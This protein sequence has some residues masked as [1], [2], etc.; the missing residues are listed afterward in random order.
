M[1]QRVSLVALTMLLASTSPAA[2]DKWIVGAEMGAALTLERDDRVDA[3]GVFA[4]AVGRGFSIGRSWELSLQLNVPMPPGISAQ[5]PLTVRWWPSSTG[6]TVHGAVRPILFAVGVCANDTDRCPM[7]D[8]LE[9]RDRG[10]F[11]L[12]VL[13]G[14]GLGYARGRLYGEVSYLAGWAKGLERDD[15]GERPRTGF[16]HG[17]LFSF[18][19][20]L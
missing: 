12:G 3:G 9:P 6:L 14:A 5:L 18:G 7:D 4:L 13:G 11:A 20:R 17:I 8:A 16:Y 1:I 2:A 10:G 15:G 19:A